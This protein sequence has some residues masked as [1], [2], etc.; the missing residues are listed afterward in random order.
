MDNDCI[1]ALELIETLGE[2]PDEWMDF[3][4]PFSEAP[5]ELQNVVGKLIDAGWIEARRAF[6]IWMAG[7]DGEV[8]LKMEYE[9]AAKDQIDE[10][11][12][13]IPGAP[14]QWYD[15]GVLRGP[16]TVRHHP[17]EAIRLSGR[18]ARVLQNWPGTLGYTIETALSEPA[19]GGRAQILTDSIV[20]TPAEEKVDPRPD[21]AELSQR[22]FARIAGLSEGQVSRLS[23]QN[24]PMTI[25]EARRRGRETKAKRRANRPE[26]DREVEAK[27]RRAGL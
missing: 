26:T 11:I 21:D 13:N 25:V 1:L 20:V 10:I 22:E 6:T 12:R 8:S 9:G 19:I 15:K 16:L 2:R 7:M 27:C 3:E 14:A 4:R 24:V 18:L 17:I 23:Q 5:R